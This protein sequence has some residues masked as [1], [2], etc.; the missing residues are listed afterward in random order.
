[1]HLVHR[2]VAQAF[3][4]EPTT[5]Q[6]CVIHINRNKSDNRAENLKWVTASESQ[7]Y[8]PKRKN[9]SARFKGVYRDQQK[10]RRRAEIYFKGQ[11]K[12]LGLFKMKRTPEE[13]TMMKPE[14]IKRN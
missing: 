11:K 5:S 10:Q 4:E 6:T 14:K 7:S 1:M 3:L 13:H 12:R 9:A 8:K 2:L